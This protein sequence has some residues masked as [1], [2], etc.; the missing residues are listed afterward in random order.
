MRLFCKKDIEVVAVCDKNQLRLNNTAKAFKIPATYDNADT[1][2]NYGAV[3]DAIVIATQDRDH[4]EHCR[5]AIDAGYKH[6]LVEKP[7]SPDIAA[8]EELLAY[9]KEKGVDIVVCH[10]LRYSK[11]YS[12][13]KKLIDDGE[14]G[15]IMNINHV[16]NVGY[17][18]YAHSYVRG[19]WHDSLE[20]SP[21]IMAKCCHDFDLFHWFIGKPCIA[22]SLVW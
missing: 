1:L 4:I 21:F 2:F 12:I 9:S 3:A 5:Q 8:C 20:T 11:H 18:H 19:C 10:V 7:V 16:E 22:V 17:F 14:I 15:E 13:I 6:I